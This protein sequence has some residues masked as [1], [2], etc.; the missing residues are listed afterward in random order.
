MRRMPFERPT[1]YYDEKLL[2][3]DEELCSLLQQRKQVSH[4]NPGYPKL[5][6]ILQN[7]QKSIICMRT[8]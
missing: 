4:N 6:K 2:P 7:G 3:I 1:E 8:F 5:S